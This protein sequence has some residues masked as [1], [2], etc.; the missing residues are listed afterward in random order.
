MYFILNRAWPSTWFMT[1]EV[2]NYTCLIGLYI[3]IAVQPRAGINPATDRALGGAGRCNICLFQTF[4][5]GSSKASSL[6]AA[7]RRR[8]V[9]QPEVC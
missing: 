3:P 1:K 9:E 6:A 5:F 4:V 7:G 2:G 8:F